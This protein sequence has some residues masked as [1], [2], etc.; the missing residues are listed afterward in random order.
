MALDFSI[1]TELLIGGTL[2]GIEGLIGIFLSV[3]IALMISRKISDLFEIGFLNM[4][5]FK[6]GFGITINLPLMIMIGI[7]AVFNLGVIQIG[8]S[9]LMNRTTKAIKYIIDSDFRERMEVTKR[10]RKAKLVK[11]EDIINK[12]KKSKMK[13][14]INTI[15]NKLELIDLGKDKYDEV[16]IK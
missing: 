15:T 3:I 7:I 1:I 4:V 9:F 6:Y 14:A 5:L 10:G 11:F 2:F 12:A 8:G 16:E 13:E